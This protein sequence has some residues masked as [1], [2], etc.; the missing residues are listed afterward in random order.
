[1]SIGK[2]K[3]LVTWVVD[4]EDHNCLLPPGCVGELLLEGPLVSCGYLKDPEKTASSS[5]EDPIWLL[6]GAPD[7]PGRHGR[8][9]KTGDLVR[10]KPDGSLIFITRKDAQVKIR[11]QR[12][13]LGDIEYWVQL[14]VPDALS[15]VAEVI[16][17]QG[18]SSS[19]VLAVFVQMNSKRSDSNQSGDTVPEILP[20]P[21][22]IVDRLAEHLPV[23]M[24]PKI[25]FSLSEL[26]LTTTGKK[27]R[28]RIREMGSLFSIEEVAETQ[29]TNRGP[30]RQPTC[31]IEQSIQKL[32]AQVLKVNA[33][34]IGLDDSFFHRGGDSITA[35]QLVAEARKINLRL[36]VADIFRFPRLQGLANQS[37]QSLAETAEEVPSFGL[38]GRDVDVPSLLQEVS[39]QHSVR[40]NDIRDI[41][42]CTPLQ[43]GLIS[44]TIRRAGD[45]IAQVIL[46]L[47]PTVVIKTLCSALEQVSR[48]MPILRTRLIQCGGGLDFAQVILDEQVS[49]VNATGLEDYLSADRKRSMDLGK[50]LRAMRS[51]VMV[52]HNSLGGSYGRYTM[53]FVMGGL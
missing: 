30:K 23:Y 31:E 49:W 9:Y 48:A 38:L 43:E 25:F 12:I 42:P 46:E 11:G 6:R 45:Y 17:F 16:K 5:I 15:A 37:I 18:E 28:K 41:Y 52:G 1:M 35:M 34:K 39:T 14:C 19:Q 24:M 29:T 27:D 21:A 40:L 36:E 4:P 33:S 51:L 2:G 53:H 50:R 22:E 20:I 3:G 13:E 10:Y 47:D 8:L 32:W 7:L 26:P 44:L